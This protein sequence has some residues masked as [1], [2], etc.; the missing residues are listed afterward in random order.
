MSGQMMIKSHRQYSLLNQQIGIRIPYDTKSQLEHRSKEHNWNN[1]IV[2][3][4]DNNIENNNYS[5]PNR[6]FMFDEAELN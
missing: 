6:I 3:V 1:I 2:N 4:S 5:A